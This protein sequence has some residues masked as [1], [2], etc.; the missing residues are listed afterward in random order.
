MALVSKE[1]GGSLW[2]P[3]TLPL[4]TVLLLLLY[5]TSVGREAR[6]R[7]GMLKEKDGQK[8]G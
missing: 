5:Q 4:V 7:A 1:G 2:S 6:E 8:G 3:T